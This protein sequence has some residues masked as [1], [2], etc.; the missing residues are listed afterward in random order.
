MSSIWNTLQ[1]VEFKQTYINAGGVNTRVIEAGSG[2]VLI[3]LHCTGGHAEAYLRNIEEHAKHFR[4]MA[5]DM[6]GHGYSDMPDIDY[7]PQDYVDFML[8]FIDAIGADKVSISGESLGAQVAAWFA[9]QHPE[10]IN[11]IVMNTGI[12]LPPDPEGAKDLE[13]LLERTRKATGAPDREAVRMRLRWLVHEDH[14]VTDELIE[15]RYQIYAQPGRAA[16]VR[17]IAE[18]SIGALL[19]SEI[20]EQWNTADLMKQIGVPTLL[21]WTK[22]NPGQLVPLAEEGAKLIPD[23][24][25]IIL[26]NSAHWPQWEEPEEFNRVHIEYLLK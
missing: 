19:I 18:A 25:L 20:Q 7:N 15:C 24:E 26:Q 4:V 3:F 10:R 23:C 9:I 14:S 17:K 1:G 21:L 12:L 6:V 11:K 16:T 13:D 5:I 2:P 22:Y 8:D